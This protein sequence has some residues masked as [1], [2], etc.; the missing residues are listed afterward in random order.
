MVHY[1]ADLQTCRLYSEVTKCMCSQSN[2]A[3]VD[4]F[5]FF[6]VYDVPCK[7]YNVQCIEQFTV[8]KS[9]ECIRTAVEFVVHCTVDNVQ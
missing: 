3:I 2:A 5:V 7:L 8:Y 1:H 4:R 6:K 9:G